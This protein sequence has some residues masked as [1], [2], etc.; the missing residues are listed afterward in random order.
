MGPTL[1]TP[2]LSAGQQPVPLMVSPDR[3]GPAQA[4]V[5]VVVWPVSPST[6]AQVAS[7]SQ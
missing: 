5:S 6:G 2:L 4:G 3:T 7:T 1:L